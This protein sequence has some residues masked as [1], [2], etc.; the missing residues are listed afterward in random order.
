MTQLLNG[1]RSFH[2][3]SISNCTVTVN[4]AHSEITAQGVRS[5][6]QQVSRQVPRG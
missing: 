5:A 4:R 3:A 1:K 2:A 6:F